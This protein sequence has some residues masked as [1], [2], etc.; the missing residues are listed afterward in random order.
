V[1]TGLARDRLLLGDEG[2]E[3]LGGAVGVDHVEEQRLGQYRVAAARGRVWCAD[4]VG[5]LVEP[6]RRDGVD[7][8]LELGAADLVLAFEDPSASILP[9]RG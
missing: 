6:L 8:A 5:Q 4:P 7:L 9:S 2:V 3:D 1:L